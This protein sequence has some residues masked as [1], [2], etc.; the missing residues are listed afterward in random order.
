MKSWPS[1]AP[2]DGAIKDLKRIMSEQ[3]AKNPCDGCLDVG[4][5]NCLACIEADKT[6]YFTVITFAPA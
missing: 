4:V 1:Y 2:S 6:A 3:K 5:T